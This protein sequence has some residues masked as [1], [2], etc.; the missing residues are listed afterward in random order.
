MNILCSLVLISLSIVNIFN[1]HN[2]RGPGQVLGSY[3]V[4]R[5]LTICVVQ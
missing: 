3:V 1:R 2:G 5:M 4:D